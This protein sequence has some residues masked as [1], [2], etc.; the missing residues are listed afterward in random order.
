MVSSAGAGEALK[1]LGKD[2][3]AVRGTLINGR[4]ERPTGKANQAMTKILFVCMGNICR[5]PT[6]EGVFRK[7][8]TD[9]G[10]DD[11]VVIAS[12]GTHAYHV[13]EPAD[14]RA[15]QA[16]RKRGYDLGELSLIHISEPTRH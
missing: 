11:S 10:L 14:V 7:M 2:V 4:D 13:G 15:Q 12:A 16:A 3:P 5:S 6:A 9:G 8:V 1:F